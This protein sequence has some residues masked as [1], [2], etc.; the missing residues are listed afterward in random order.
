MT[1]LK[2]EELPLKKEIETKPFLK[3]LIMYIGH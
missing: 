3:N 2:L 1:N